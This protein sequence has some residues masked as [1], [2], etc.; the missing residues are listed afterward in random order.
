MTKKKQK[1]LN[2]YIVDAVITES[3]RVRVHL[4]AEDEPT[5][6]ELFRSI[7]REDYVELS[8]E[9]TLNLLSV[10]EIDDVEV[11][12]DEDMEDA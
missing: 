7:K 4:R 10:D 2:Y 11:L 1:K 3:R 12:D 5:K 6:E 9:E 8:E